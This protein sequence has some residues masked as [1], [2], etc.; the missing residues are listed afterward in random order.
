MLR[1]KGVSAA[2]VEPAYLYGDGRTRRGDAVTATLDYA[3]LPLSFS[4]GEA[5]RVWVD[6]S[7]PTMPILQPPPEIV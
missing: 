1:L 7:L 5:G 2:R 6:R 3:Q 4:L